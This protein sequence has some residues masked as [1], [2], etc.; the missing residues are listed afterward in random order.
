MSGL[1]KVMAPLALVSALSGGGALAQS[2]NQVP[3][4]SAAITIDGV[5]EPAWNDAL[6]IDGFTQIEPDGG[7][8]ATE[9]LEA[10]LKT[11]GKNLY[12]LFL[13]P[14]NHVTAKSGL[15]DRETSS[16]QFALNL[17]TTGDPQHGI[18]TTT[19]RYVLEA[20][21]NAIDYLNGDLLWNQPKRAAAKRDYSGWIGELAIPLRY[22]LH[23]TDP[24][25]TWAIE[26]SARTMQNAEGKIETATAYARSREQ[27]NDFG[28][29]H[30]LVSLSVIEPTTA[31]KMIVSPSASTTES[32]R[33]PQADLSYDTGSTRMMLSLFPSFLASGLPPSVI[34]HQVAE[35][36]QDEPRRLFRGIDQ[37]PMVQLFYSPRI[38][39]EV[40]A[41]AKALV[42][43]GRNRL[44]FVDGMMRE[45][46]RNIVYAIDTYQVGPTSRLGAA[47]TH[48]SDE[49]AQSSSAY[50]LFAQLEPVN[51]WLLN[52]TLAEARPGN[53]TADRQG[54]IETGFS[55]GAG[56][57]LLLS[58]QEVGPHFDVNPTGYITTV[59]RIRYRAGGSRNWRNAGPF[60]SITLDGTYLLA[61]IHDG[62]SAGDLYRGALAVVTSGNHNA[63]LSFDRW[64]DRVTLSDGTDLLYWADALALSLGSDSRRRVEGNAR[65]SAE[66]AY[67][68]EDRMPIRV[69]GASS[70]LTLHLDNGN[71]WASFLSNTEYDDHGL[72]DRRE[73]YRAGGDVTL[74]QRLGLEGSVDYST[75]SRALRGNV[76]L[77]WVP[78]PDQG[79]NAGVRFEEGKKAEG[80]VTVALRVK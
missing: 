12:V 73:Q 71:A 61:K 15:P 49:G 6:V 25:Q 17:G 41:A 36:W 4:D 72:H 8:P 52:A 46:A 67:D 24:A 21:G 2:V 69:F 70:G 76:F 68:F 55:D 7:Q 80:Y 39:G 60:S 48:R 23:S 38:E 64:G 30:G 74:L 32:M 19:H 1:Q 79:V 37:A 53:G 54:S 18:I 29:H 50:E 31:A 75:V 13:A 44:T 62:R 65:L 11:D 42:Q 43:N 57:S 51:N 59:D 22:I 14:T 45:P 56:N 16:D 34:G 58:F 35:A 5:M 77:K 3:T 28:H 66:H 26:V 47:I 27:A 40:I 10:R 33:W 20:S 63:R 9:P 78:D